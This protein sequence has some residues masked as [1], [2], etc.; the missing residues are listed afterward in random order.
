[1]TM[2][3]G[4]KSQISEA[5]R[6]LIH[7]HGAEV[8]VA[9][10]SSAPS[11]DLTRASFAGQYLS[12]LNVT[13][14]E[15]L[16]LAIKQC[17]CSCYSPRLRAYRS[18]YAGGCGNISMA[19]I[20]Q[21]MVPAEMAGVL[22]TIDP[23]S[24]DKKSIALEVTTGLGDGIAAGTEMGVSLTAN[25]KTFEITKVLK[26][27]QGIDDELIEQT[28]WTTL[29]K[30]A[31]QIE[32]H[33]HAPQDIEWVFSNQR[34]WILQS[35]PITVMPHRTCRQIWTRANAGEILPGVV[36][37]LTWS[38]FKPTLLAA[39]LHKGKSLLTL[40]WRW[41]HPCGSRPDSPRLLFGRAYMELSSVYAG[42]CSL[43]GVDKD[44]LQRLLGFEFHVC[45]EDE[46]P[47][48]RLR[49]HIMDPVRGMLYWIEMLGMTN[50]LSRKAKRWM[51]HEI[52]GGSKSCSPAWRPAA[53]GSC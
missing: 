12:V 21:L 29:L 32:E 2:P 10:R 26:S 5:Y 42:F 11:E 49:W 14:E 35:R 23:S 4:L 44:I 39:G 18:R 47:M 40:H 45:R 43:P 20:V 24:T 25:R 51:A 7:G 53:Q 19:V 28:D 33:M 30:L 38:V 27:S 15:E 52:W 3:P 36:T 48:K 46:I 17:W 16:V 1:M 34:F 6:S 31:L 22:F 41:H 13:D 8:K 37:P 50:T 9:V